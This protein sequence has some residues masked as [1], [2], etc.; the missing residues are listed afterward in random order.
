MKSTAPAVVAQERLEPLDGVD[1][2]VVGGLVEQQHV[3]RGHERARQQ[4]APAPAARQ[5]VHRR[6]GRQIE[7]GEH[8]SRRAARASSRRALRAR[9][10]GGPSRRAPRGCRAPPRPRRGGRRPR[11]PPDRRGPAPPR[12]TPCRACRAARPAPAAPPARRCRATRR[13]RR[14]AARRS[15]SA[16]A[17]TCR[18]RSGRS[19]RGVPPA[20]SAATRRRAGAGGRRRGRYGRG[21]AGAFDPLSV[22]GWEAGASRAGAHGF[23]GAGCVCSAATG[24]TCTVPIRPPSA[25]SRM[26]Q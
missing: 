21:S 9:A 6:V 19:G 24:P 13:P 20:G 22:S 8:Q 5:G 4:H 10:A 15:R 11:A 2:E 18:C 3:G 23:F 17:W 25:W 7:A 14:A 1:V 16:S 26:W 12:R